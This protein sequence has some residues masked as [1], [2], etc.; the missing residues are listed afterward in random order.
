MIQEIHE[1]PKFSFRIN[2]FS[3]SVETTSIALGTQIKWHEKHQ[4]FKKKT[5]I[6]KMSLICTYE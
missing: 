5:E 4:K 1:R 3:F 6:A 2:F